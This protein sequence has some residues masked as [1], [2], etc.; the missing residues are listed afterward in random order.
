M[1]KKAVEAPKPKPATKAKPVAKAKQ[2]P[3]PVEEVIEAPETQ[4]DPPIG[5]Y[6][7]FTNTTRSFIGVI[8]SLTPPVIIEHS[9]ANGVHTENEL[10]EASQWQISPVSKEEVFATLY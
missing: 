7:R 9:S 4:P 8:Q 1:A 5:V 3:K 2:A 6:L 10:T